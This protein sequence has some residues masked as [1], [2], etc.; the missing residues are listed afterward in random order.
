MHFRA[1]TD[2]ISSVTV[3]TDHE[4]RLLAPLFRDLKHKFRHAAEGKED[5]R[6][7][8]PLVEDAPRD[9]DAVFPGRHPRGIPL[10]GDRFDGKAHLPRKIGETGVEALDVA[11]VGVG[12]MLLFTGGLAEQQDE[13]ARFVELGGK[14]AEG[15]VLSRIH[16]SVKADVQTFSP[17]RLSAPAPPGSEAAASG[18]CF[19]R[20]NSFT[21]S[22]RKSSSGPS[23]PSR[24]ESMS[25]TEH[26]I[27]GNTW[28]M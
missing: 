23:S 24:S 3:R 11:A 10:V 26:A 4:L 6:S 20:L 5:T 16:K 8:I 27:A 9:R 17:P 12:L 25:M 28:K 2:I 18:S 1:Q 7:P 19:L 14:P 22:G 21:R 15:T 13:I